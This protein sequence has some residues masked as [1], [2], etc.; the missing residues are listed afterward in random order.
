MILRGA[1]IVMLVASL[2][3]GC[4]A[5]TINDHSVVGPDLPGD[6]PFAGAHEIVITDTRN[7]GEDAGEIQRIDIVHAG[8]QDSAT[9]VNVF[10]NTSKPFNAGVGYW[11]F[12]PVVAETHAGAET[13]WLMS[14]N[15]TR[16]ADRSV[17]MIFRFPK[18]IS[19]APGSASDALEYATVDCGDLDVA[20]HP[21]D[22][23]APKKDGE[24][25]PEP[26]LDPVP[27]AGV[28]E[29][30]SSHE[31]Q[32]MVPLMLKKYDQI[33]RYDDAPELVWQPV[34]VEVK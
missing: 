10:G 21:V 19:L 11:S 4:T 7:S 1:A 28:C 8:T 14:F 31:L 25:R 27:E 23:Y 24:T 30:N 5:K 9:L 29:F 12:T 3:A 6:G 34:H 26:P 13:Y 32:V 20:R 16:T 2:L 33:H 22:Y 15:L 17:Y 18:E